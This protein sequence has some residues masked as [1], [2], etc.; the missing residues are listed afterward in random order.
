V[1]WLL[2]TWLGCS[3][4]PMVDPPD[5]G[6]EG[7]GGQ[8]TLQWRSQVYGDDS[9]TSPFEVEFCGNWGLEAF[10]WG[11]QEFWFI[12]EF[13]LI[14][15]AQWMDD[16]MDEGFEEPQV[17]FTPEGVNLPFAGEELEFRSCG[18]TGGADHGRL[19]CDSGGVAEWSQDWSVDPGVSV[20][21]QMTWRCD[22]EQF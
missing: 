20:G 2:L 6:D 4:P 8:M 7:P 21:V 1:H 13:P 14:R 17:W 19:R 5:R 15:E 18:L 3:Q 12:F 22:V 10:T 9:W 16:W 11:D